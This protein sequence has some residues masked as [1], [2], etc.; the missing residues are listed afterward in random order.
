MARRRRRHGRRRPDRGG[1]LDRQGRPRGARA[2]GRP[3][4]LDRGGGR[5]HVHG[6]ASPWARSPPERVRLPCRRR[7]RP[8][9]GDGA[10]PA[11]EAPDRAGPAERPSPP[12]GDAEWPRITPVARR[13]ALENGI[14]PG[15]VTG[16]GPGGMSASPTCRRRSARAPAPAAHRG[17]PPR[18]SARAR[19]RRPCAA[20]PPR[21]RATWTT[22]CRSPPPRASARSRSR[23]STPSGGRSTTELKTAGRSEKL[24]FTHL[25]AWAIVT[26]GGRAA[27]HDHRV[28]ADRRQPA[29]AG[30]PRGE[31]RPRG[32][33]GAQGRQPLAARAG[34]ARRRRRRLPRL[35]RRLRRPG[36]PRPGR[37]GQAGRAARRQHQP[38]EPGRPR[39]GGLGAAPDAGTGHDHR[40]RRHRLPGRLRIGG[41][42]GAPRAGRARR[43]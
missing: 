4:R 20:R 5:G 43:S 18:P 33:R 42:R 10:L 1:G 31:H 13:L 27:V 7:R 11:T 21:S 25:I 34:G 39:H 35:P 23:C 8:G 17:P 28:R 3:A 26:R 6:W 2:G 9:N 36:E 32:G 19:R 40:H 29:Q 37:Q 12:A 15:A 22:A 16:T 30:A 24:S 38:H 41:S 14:D